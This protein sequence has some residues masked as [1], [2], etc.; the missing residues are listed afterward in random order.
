MLAEIAYLLLI[1]CMYLLACLWLKI[2]GPRFGV[3]DTEPAGYSGSLEVLRGIAAFLVFGAHTTMYFPLAPAQVIAGGMG[4]VGV[5]LFFMLTAHLFWGQVIAGKFNANTFFKKRIR[6]L[7]P[8]MIA[9]VGVYTFLDWSWAGFPWPTTAQMLGIIRNF[10][11]G[12]G[13]VT[14]G[15]G[16]VN[17]IF[18]KD[19]YLKFNVIWTLQ[20]EWFFYLCL[21]LLA[22]IKRFR[23]ISLFAMLVCLMW[24]DP[25]QISSGG[26]NVVFIIAFWLGALSSTMEIYRSSLLAAIF[27][28]EIGKVIIFL[29]IIV[30]LTYFLSGEKLTPKNLRVPTMVFLVFPIFFYFVSTKY[31]KSML[32]WPSMRVIGKISYSFYLWHLGVSTYVFNTFGHI[33]GGRLQQSWPLFFITLLVEMLISITLSVITYRFVEAPFLGKI[34]PENWRSTQNN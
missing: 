1:A 16:S 7:V 18:S 13:A 20:W 11:F 31:H 3:L 23:Y 6:R 4:N 22:A 10:G 8:A 34:K 28:K 17:D 26:T 24:M 29:G 30:I 14:N 32:S 25:F 19:L 33:F 2:I 12:F 27:N 5:F 15:Y 21:P 9:V